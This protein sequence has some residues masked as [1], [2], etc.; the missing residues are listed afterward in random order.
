VQGVSQRC[1]HFIK[2]YLPNFE[3]VTRDT[4]SAATHYFHGLFQS[5]KCN[6]E[7]MEEA[8]PNADEQQLQH[9][10]SVSPWEEDAV[11]AQIT[12]EA[13][14]T[15]GGHPDSSLIVDESAITKK[16]THSAG[17]ARQYNGR[18]GKIDNCQVGVF[19]ALSHGTEACL[20]GARLYL[21]KEWTKDPK[22]CRSVGIPKEHIRHR[23]KQTL[24]LELITQ[25]REDGAK[26]SWVLVD[27]GY[28]HDLP[29]C[30]TLEEQLQETFIVGVHKTQRI[31]LDDP[32]PTIPEANK[33]GR[34]PT[35][36]RSQTSPT[37]VKKWAK[38]QR[39]S[40]WKPLTL[41]DSTK[42]ELRVEVLWRRVWVWDGRS[43][44]GRNWWLLVQRDPK[45]H[46]DYKYSLSNAA[47]S[48]SGEELCRQRAQRFWVERVFEDAKGQVG[49]D[50]YQSRG[51]RSWH[52]HMAMVSM[53]LLFLLEERQLHKPQYPL[54]SCADVLALLCYAL[55]KR[56]VTDEEMMRQLE[57]R[58]RKRTASIEYHHRKQR[59][60]DRVQGMDG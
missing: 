5:E 28:G 55:P 56:K 34:T 43:A 33:P 15:L 50:E 58:H 17:V 14:A 54:L 37:T 10:L 9:F 60:M 47:P 16:G 36:L 41:R 20:I 57:Q 13:N 45:T 4:F 21:P 30:Q 25:A 12:R 22:R 42:G 32:K 39:T 49:L 44:K 7:R 23:T 29:F 1:L 8:V 40:A 2:R 59:V 24:A 31:Y 38:A 53:A 35:R 46:A 48:A 11:C 51:W 3:T 27:G 19:A 52:H 26:F 18:L 6:M